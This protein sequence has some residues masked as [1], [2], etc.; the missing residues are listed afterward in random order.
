MLGFLFGTVCLIGLVKVARG[1]CYGYAGH[2]WG[3]GGGG[4]GGEDGPRGWHRGAKTR[5]DLRP[6]YGNRRPGLQ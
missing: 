5:P 3:R 4:F 2:G 6:R 1:S